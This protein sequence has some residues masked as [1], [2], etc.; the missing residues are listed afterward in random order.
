MNR[1]AAAIPPEVEAAIR[2]ALE[3]PERTEAALVLAAIANRAAAALHQLARAEANG[4]KGTPS[5]GRWAALT[6]AARDAVLRT[7][8][9]RQAA[10]Q[11]AQGLGAPPADANG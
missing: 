3:H 2:S 5:W 4:R 8:T 1:A 11:L 9:C 10:G 7:A 6:N